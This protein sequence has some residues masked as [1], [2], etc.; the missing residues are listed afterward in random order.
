MKSKYKKIRE[1]AKEY[2]EFLKSR[3]LTSSETDPDSQNYQLYEWRYKFGNVNFWACDLA[4][5]S[6]P[7]FKPVVY[8]CNW[9]KEKNG[10]LCFYDVQDKYDCS[11]EYRIKDFESFKKCVDKVIKIIK[12][13]YVKSKELEIQQ[14]FV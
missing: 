2:I 14:D 13:G 7:E 12:T 8:K 9:K 11:A 3:G 1:Q 5:G 6:E 4:I 10:K